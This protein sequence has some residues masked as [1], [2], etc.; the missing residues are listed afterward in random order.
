MMEEQKG[1]NS[2]RRSYCLLS[3]WVPLRC[4]AADEVEAGADTL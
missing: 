3:T 4:E 2:A 1:V